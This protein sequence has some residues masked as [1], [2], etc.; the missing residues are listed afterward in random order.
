MPDPEPGEENRKNRTSPNESVRALALMFD[1]GL[2]LALPIVIGVVGGAALDSALR[3]SPW[4]LFVGVLVRVGVAFYA[5]YD[6][7][8]SFGSR[9]R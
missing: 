1:L 9:K 7:S 4:L 6:V 8:R 3:T 2:R 5:M